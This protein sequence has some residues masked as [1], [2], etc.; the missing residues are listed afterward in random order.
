[1]PKKVD[2]VLPTMFDDLGGRTVLEVGVAADMVAV[3]VSVHDDQREGSA[4]ARASSLEQAV[5]F[6]PQRRT[7]D[8]RVDQQRAVA[9]D[10]QIYERRLKGRP[11]RLPDSKCP[12]VDRLGLP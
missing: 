9:T 11:D 4:V 10:Y 1:M 12:A 7:R 5:H 6:T 2:D 8:A 3:T